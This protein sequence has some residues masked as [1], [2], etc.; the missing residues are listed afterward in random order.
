MIGACNDADNTETGPCYYAPQVEVPRA[1]YDAAEEDGE[2]TADECR[3]LCNKYFEAD[4]SGET[5]S[6]ASPE[7]MIEAVGATIVTMHCMTEIG[8]A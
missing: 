8:C 1:D 3:T 6:L 2:L 4:D 5:T 7:C